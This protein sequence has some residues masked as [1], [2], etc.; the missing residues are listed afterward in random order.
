MFTRFH[1]GRHLASPPQTSS[2]PGAARTLPTLSGL[3]SA[4]ALFASLPPA[5]WAAVPVNLTGGAFEL[6][7]P[8]RLSIW[9]NTPTATL[10]ID[11][12]G[13]RG[14][15]NW[16]VVWN[17][18]LA[19]S[20]VSTPEGVVVGTSADGR[21]IESTAT[22]QPGEKQV[23]AMRPNMGK[24]YEFAVFGNLP[25]GD[26]RSPVVKKLAKAIS[27]GGGQF[28]L[29]L[30]DAPKSA[31]VSELE[32]WRGLLPS[33]SF[34]TY[35]INAH[36]PGP[37][38]EKWQTL[39]GDTQQVFRL[40]LDAF[41]LLENATGHLTAAQEAWLIKSLE[42]LRKEP[43]RHIFVLAH[44]PLVDVRPGINQ[45][46]QDRQQVRRL[47]KTF[48]RHQ[49]HTV[50]AGRLGFFATESRQGVRYVTTGGA[51]DRL[52]LPA[53]KGGFHHWVRVSVTDDGRVAV[54]PEPLK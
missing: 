34:P 14:F 52:A 45:G 21:P 48:S 29:H 16:R 38:R 22:L 7:A 20:F 33:L 8:D 27:A 37:L 36:P 13:N 25:A 50:F 32:Q 23:W 35:C 47:L 17:N 12:Q 42:S 4:L 2:P 40:G 28:A 3:L 46:M 9:P 31:K 1:R 53:A 19:G 44:R 5:A 39:F 54:K 15:A 51:G 11:N 41:V 49:V 30:G 26:K 43:T 6:T 10:A 18:C 24:R